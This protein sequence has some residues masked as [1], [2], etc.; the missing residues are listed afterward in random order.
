MSK[1]NLRDLS[2]EN[3]VQFKKKKKLVK[4]FKF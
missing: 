2:L 1:Y 4:M 3:A